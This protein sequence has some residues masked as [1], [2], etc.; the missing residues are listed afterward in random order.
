MTE[1]GKRYVHQ[2]FI[3]PRSAC[4]FK[5]FSRVLSELNRLFRLFQENHAKELNENLTKWLEQNFTE[6]FN[7]ISSSDHICNLMIN[8]IFPIY[9]SNQLIEKTFVSKGKISEK[10][11]ILNLDII[12]LSKINQIIYEKSESDR[13][14]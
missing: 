14:W 5:A 9:I 3:D 4:T 13:C 12:E 8:V 2:C 1:K 7:T 6:K 10:D 11:H